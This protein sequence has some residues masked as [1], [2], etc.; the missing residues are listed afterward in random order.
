M[1]ARCGNV[2]ES[3]TLVGRRFC[4]ER[5]VEGAVELGLLGEELCQLRFG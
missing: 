5:C 3:T 2:R 4:F 1:M